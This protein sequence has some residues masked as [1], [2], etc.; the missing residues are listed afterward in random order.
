MRNIVASRLHNRFVVYFILIYDN[1]NYNKSKVLVIINGNNIVISTPYI[2]LLLHNL[3]KL[4]FKI[5]AIEKGIFAT[6]SV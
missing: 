3:L 5:L 2:F 6:R 1:S 4:H